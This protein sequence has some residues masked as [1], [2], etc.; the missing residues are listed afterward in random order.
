[1]QEEEQEQSGELNAIPF[2]ERPGENLL[3]SK[4]NPSLMTSIR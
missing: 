3:G 2:N 4:K 1:M